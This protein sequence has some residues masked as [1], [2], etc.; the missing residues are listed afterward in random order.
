VRSQDAIRI[1]GR[2]VK[3][4]SERV[5]EL[6]LRNGHRL[7]AFLTGRDRA[8]RGP[9]QAG[10]TLRVEVSAFDFSKGRIRVES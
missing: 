6:E 7:V 3:V 8:V 4:I 2:I 1:E 5:A 10:E 9:L